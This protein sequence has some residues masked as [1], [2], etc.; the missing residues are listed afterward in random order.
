MK[1]ATV[2]WLLVAVVAVVLLLPAWDCT[3]YDCL[4]F[5]FSFFSYIV[6]VFHVRSLFLNNKDEWYTDELEPVCLSGRLS[7]ACLSDDFSLKHHP[8]RYRQIQLSSTVH[9]ALADLITSHLTSFKMN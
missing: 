8:H 3:S 5:W 1:T 6:L 7:R 9:I 2:A 4:G